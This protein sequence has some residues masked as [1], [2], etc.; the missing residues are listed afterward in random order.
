[1]SATVTVSNFNNPKDILS[2]VIDG[3]H[4]ARVIKELVEMDR[5]YDCDDMSLHLSEE[6]EGLED[7]DDVTE[8]SFCDG[9]PLNWCLNWDDVPPFMY[10][11]R[12]KGYREERMKGEDRRVKGPVTRS[13]RKRALLAAAQPSYRPAKCRERSRTRSRS[14]SRSR[15]PKRW[16][17]RG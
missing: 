9:V 3:S 14:R 13:R 6:L 10:V 17:F 8:W 12:E 2:Y 16:P 7:P 1:M 15:S 5:G 11:V 4:H